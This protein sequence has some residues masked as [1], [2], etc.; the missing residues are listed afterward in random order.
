VL[1][2]STGSGPLNVRG[3]S[4]PGSG[5]DIQGTSGAAISATNAGEVLLNDMDMTL[6]G[7]DGV[8]ATSVEALAVY[9]S[10][11]T[12]GASGIVAT[13]ISDAQAYDLLSFDIE[14]N[15]LSLQQDSAISLTYEDTSSGSL[16][17]NQ[18]GSES[19]VAG[20]VTGDG[21]YLAPVGAGTLEASLSNNIVDQIDAGIGIDA[22]APANS[23]LD[24]TLYQNEVSMDSP[25]S[26]DGVQ[27]GSSGT[28]CLNATGNDVMAAG[29]S[30]SA[31]GMELDLTSGS[32]FEIQ[33]LD[34]DPVD[35]V[36]GV[37]TLG[38]AIGYGAPAAVTNGSDFVA[39]PAGGCPAPSGSAAD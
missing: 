30:S 21:I 18:I 8:E 13:G 35:Y 33:G 3:A 17:Q 25:T 6:D 1:L 7:G 19:P 15:V 34:T 5:G 29:Q 4:L 23:T 26:Q 39:A 2:S 27:V 31:N 12:G 32:V 37:N 11:I 38:A 28:V 24:L 22:Q 16:V 14:Y 10:Q 20:S 9:S 36:T